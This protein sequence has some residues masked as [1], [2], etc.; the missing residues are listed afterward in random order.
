[1]LSIGINIKNGAKH[2]ELCLNALQRF[3]EIILLDN[4]STDNT[5]LIAKTYPNVRIFQH[6]FLGMG[7]LRNMAAGFAT[8]DWVFF[9]DCDEIVNQDL[10]N[11]LLDFNFKKNHVY[12]IL[13]LN[14]Y[15]NKQI[16]SSSWENDWVNR[17]YNKN[18][19]KYIDCS[20]HESI[21][22][23][24]MNVQKIDVGHIYH[25]P[26]EEVSAL[27]SKM[28]FYSTLYAQQNFLKKEAKLFLIPFRSI[29]M[30][31]K[32]YFL[33]AGFR[34]GY[35][36]FLVSSF[37]AIGVFVKY[38]KLYEL[39]HKKTLALKIAIDSL[40]IK[41]LELL[42]NTI[43]S[44]K[45][46]PKFVLLVLEDKITGANGSEI[47]NLF[48]KNLIVPSMIRQKT[49]DMPQLE[50]TENTIL[51]SNKIDY[52]VHIESPSFLKNKNFLKLCRDKIRKNKTISGAS[53]TRVES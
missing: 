41:K 20:V 19:T 35:E 13:R 30:F 39:S 21:D 29:V 5:L 43:N 36:G 52:L 25:F 22:V 6:E 34:D 15:D 10:V 37:N 26:Y 48:K 11:T 31:I 40:N 51:N 27:V 1:M 47:N 28:Q 44:Q 4:Y 23:A 49:P 17:I 24:K 53:F 7:N 18:E 8:N 46:L 9:V 50:M 38:I 33:K 2:L 12:S 42:I 3:S 14:Y 16:N 45:V 32:C